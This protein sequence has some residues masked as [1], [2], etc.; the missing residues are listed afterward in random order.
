MALEFRSVFHRDNAR[1]SLLK[2]GRTF[3]AKKEKE[4]LK[5]GKTRFFKAERGGEINSLIKYNG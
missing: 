5:N 1:R 3:R 4:I 2:R